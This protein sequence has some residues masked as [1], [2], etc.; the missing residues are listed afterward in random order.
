ML[1]KDQVLA[2]AVPDLERE[3]LLPECPVRVNRERAP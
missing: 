2:R 1:V 3:H